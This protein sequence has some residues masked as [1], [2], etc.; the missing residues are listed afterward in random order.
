[1]I[2]CTENDIFSSALSVEGHRFKPVYDF[3]HCSLEILYAYPEDSGTYMVVAMNECG[4]AEEEVEL[5]CFGDP[6]VD[7]ETQLPEGMQSMPQIQ[8]LEHAA[9]KY[10][11]KA[12]F[13]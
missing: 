9:R 4:K 1:M 8:S 10:V 2:Q 5:D 13:Q 7:E 3:G 12:L 6:S 11:T